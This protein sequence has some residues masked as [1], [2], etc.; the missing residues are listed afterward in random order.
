MPPRN[1]LAWNVCEICKRHVPT[2]EC[3][4]NNKKVKICPYCMLLFK[5]LCIDYNRESLDREII[6][7]PNEEL[8]ETL[9]KKNSRTIKRKRKQHH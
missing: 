6:L 9:S 7:S 1:T 3:R 2:F 8:I 5:N 4:I